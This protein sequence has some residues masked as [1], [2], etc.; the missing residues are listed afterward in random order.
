[1]CKPKDVKTNGDASGLRAL[2]ASGTMPQ[3]PEDGVMFAVG[4]KVYS[5][6]N[7]LMTRW[8]IPYTVTKVNGNRV[9]LE[10]Q[11]NEYKD[12]PMRLLEKA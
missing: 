4:D 1:M 9:T 12:V 2:W 3:L 8:G 6:G 7:Q 10:I 11:G 5:K